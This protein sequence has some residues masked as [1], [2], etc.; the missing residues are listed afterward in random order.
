MGRGILLDNPKEESVQTD[1]T[2]GNT[3]E[4]SPHCPALKDPAQKEEN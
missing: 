3:N 1:T 2:V 4:F